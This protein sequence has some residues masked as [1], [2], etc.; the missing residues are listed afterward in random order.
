VPLYF[1][2]IFFC[3][4]DKIDNNIKEDFKV[5][6]NQNCQE[7]IVD[8]ALKHENTNEVDKIII[9][10]SNLQG[11]STDSMQRLNK[12]DFSEKYTT[13]DVPK[14]VPL[15]TKASPVKL[16]AES[17]DV[18]KVIVFKFTVLLKVK[19]IHRVD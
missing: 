6:S 12:L 3:C 13:E 1:N 8:N 7:K 19:T 17:A 4:Q 5:L 16:F 2:I 11:S 14:K 9:E 10:N 15:I 18:D